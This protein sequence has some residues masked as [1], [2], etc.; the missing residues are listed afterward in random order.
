[1]D[2]QNLVYQMQDADLE[3]LAMLEGSSDHPPPDK[4]SS[5]QYSNMQEGEVHSI[6][7]ASGSQGEVTHIYL[8]PPKRPVPD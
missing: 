4:P 6:S 5:S 3:E 8:P 7:E 1:M 2:Q